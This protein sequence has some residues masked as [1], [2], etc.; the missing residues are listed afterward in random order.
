MFF[1]V[2]VYSFEK[3]LLEYFSLWIYSCCIA[4]ATW[5]LCVLFVQLIR[6]LM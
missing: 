1:I 3:Y 5:V 4:F 2:V 6:M